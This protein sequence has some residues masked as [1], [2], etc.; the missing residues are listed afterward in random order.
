M[1]TMD[2]ISRLPDKGFNVLRN[3]STFSNSS[4]SYWRT[5]LYFPNFVQREKIQYPHMTINP[6]AP[7]D[8]AE[9]ACLKLIRIK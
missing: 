5:I 8:L 7:R 2:I 3:C 6:L 1:F 4:H 9:S